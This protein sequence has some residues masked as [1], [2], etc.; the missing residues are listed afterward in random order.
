VFVAIALLA[1]VI[2]AWGDW[3][4]LAVAGLVA[5]GAWVTGGLIGFLFGIPRSLADQDRRGDQS[6]PSARYQANTN[7]EQISDW[8]TKILVGVGLVKFTAFARLIVDLVSFLWPAHG[9]AY[10]GEIFAGA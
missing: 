4:R 10:M 6:G 2:Y 7:L 5:G 8:L 9:G 1:I 3:A